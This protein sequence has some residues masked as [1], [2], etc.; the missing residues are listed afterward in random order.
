MFFSCKKEGCMDENAINYDS[1]A[2]QDDGSCKYLPAL[3]TIPI[4]YNGTTAQSGGIITSDGNSAVSV[5]GVCWSK[6]INPTITNDTTI[7]GTGLGSYS[8]VITNLDTNTQYYVRAYATNSN[9]T[10]YGNM[11]SFVT[12]SSGITVNVF[13]CTDPLALNYNSNANVDNGSCV[14]DSSDLVFGCTDPNAINYN[15][16]ANIDNGLC[17]YDSSDLVFG[18]M[19]PTASNY[20]SNANID[21]GSCMYADFDRE[22]MLKNLSRNYIIPAI[23][24]YNISVDSLVEAKNNFI[25]LVDNNSLN[26]LRNSWKNSLLV[27]Q[28]VSFIGPSVYLTENEIGNT[29]VFPVD[30][31][32]IF[33]NINNSVTPSI[34]D[35]K[36]F[37]AIDLLIN[38]SDNNSVIIN[39]FNT[40]SFAKD[41]LSLVVDE[42]FDISSNIKTRWYTDTTNF[43]NNNSNTS[44]GS[45]ISI[46]ANAFCK[47]YEYY[48]RRGK[49]GLPLGV[50]NGFSQQEM[51]HLVECYYYGQSLPFL[52]RSVS[53]LKKYINGESYSFA[54][55]GSGFDD[56][57]DFVGAQYGVINLSTAIN[58]KFIEI[59]NKI[60]LLNDP[61]SDELLI[62]RIAVQNLYDELEELKILLKVDLTSALGIQITYLDNDGD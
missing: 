43:I 6:S 62:N 11:L 14:Y 3:S 46:V 35:Q 17:V 56:Y 36:G 16:N 20:N 53:S 40:N 19:D 39:Y 42:I 57:I 60:S 4:T 24:A 45:S 32:S 50:F 52:S 2:N 61:L 59:D 31:S 25:S 12:N 10:S 58:N 5:R 29:N 15:P 54:N 18:C 28:D 30:S 26:N 47:Q 55:N 21:D 8:S 49:V 7:N 27:Y 41:Y 23:E 33:N 48:V 51:P 38:Y 44:V 37:Q 9:G 34:M 1:N 22:E 13:G